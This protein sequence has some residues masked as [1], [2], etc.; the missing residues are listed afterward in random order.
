[1]LQARK[2]RTSRELYFDCIDEEHRDMHIPRYNYTFSM[3]RRK[4]AAQATIEEYVKSTISSKF[5]KGNVYSEDSDS[6]SCGDQY[7][8]S[9]TLLKFFIN[10]LP[11]FKPLHFGFHLPNDVET[12]SCVC[13]CAQGC[14]RPWY[15]GRKISR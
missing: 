5:D 9:P 8:P 12:P 4:E 15:I 6:S 11:F 13:P 3:E 14:H 2:I 10:V 1:M 7:A